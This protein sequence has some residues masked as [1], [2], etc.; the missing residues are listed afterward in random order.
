[1]LEE[2]CG[3]F[4]VVALLVKH[5]RTEFSV[6]FGDAKLRMFGIIEMRI[7]E[8]GAIVTLEG[9]LF[10]LLIIVRATARIPLDSPAY[11]GAS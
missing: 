7:E 9:L 6:D 10:V 5:L 1:M 4:L 8:V 2:L 3:R 11:P